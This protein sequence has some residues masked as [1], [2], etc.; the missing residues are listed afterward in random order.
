[1][2]SDSAITRPSASSTGTLPLGLAA[3]M[4]ARVSGWSSGITVSSNG[5]S[6]CVSRIQ[7]PQRPGGIGLVAD[8]KMKTSRRTPPLPRRHVDAR[9]TPRQA[10]TF[11]CHRSSKAMGRLDPGRRGSRPLKPATEVTTLQAKLEPRR[12][13]WDA[14]WLDQPNRSPATAARVLSG[15]DRSRDDVRQACGSLTRGARP[16]GGSS[17]DKRAPS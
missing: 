1:M 17:S 9:T 3:K 4:A 13:L 7:G 2:A 15:Q 12:Q 11:S 14:M 16:E 5:I 8:G 6:K 10:K